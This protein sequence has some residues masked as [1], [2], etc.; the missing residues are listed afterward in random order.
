M[1]VDR[2]KPLLHDGKLQVGS[3]RLDFSETF[4]EQVATNHMSIESRIS[5]LYGEFLNTRTGRESGGLNAEEISFSDSKRLSCQ[6]ERREYISNSKNIYKLK[7][8]LAM[9]DMYVY[10]GQPRHAKI[11]DRYQ[12]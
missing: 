12:E 1:C 5:S 7:K 8:R 11:G 3:E 6:K 9:Q 2:C 4:P 10:N